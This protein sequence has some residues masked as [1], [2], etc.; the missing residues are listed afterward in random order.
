MKAILAS[1][2][3]VGAALGV[4]ADA[5]PSTDASLLGSWAVDVARMPLPPAAR[6]RKVTITFSDAGEGRLAMDVVIVDAAG[7]ES[8]MDSTARLDGTPIALDPN[9][10]ADSAAMRMP[11][12]GVLVLGLGRNGMPASTRTYS[13]AADGEAMTEIAS[14]VGGDGKPLLR[15]NYFSRVR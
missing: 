12:P 9:P 14:Y 6:P 5:R 1:L 15:I 10:E 13:V 4:P 3:A 7:T 2:L 11:V 8:R